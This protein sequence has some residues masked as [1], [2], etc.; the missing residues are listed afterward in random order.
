MVSYRGSDDN[1]H[2]LFLDASGTWHHNNLSEGA[3]AP[4]AAGDP[5]AYVEQTNNTEHVCYRTAEGDI[6]QLFAKYRQT[7]WQKLDMSKEANAPKAAGEPSAYRLRESRFRGVVTQH[8]VYRGEDGGIHE[9]FLGGAENKWTHN[10]LSKAAGNTPKAE[11]DP[12]GYV[13][14]AN[15]TQHV[16]FQTG[17]GRIFELYNVPDGPQRGWH[18]NALPMPG[19]RRTP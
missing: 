6:V 4:K 16:V 11:S 18:G 9:L 15:R 13:L 2:E 5:T 19:A 8:V 7:D 3:K 12:A 17:D 1:V 10:D 14:E